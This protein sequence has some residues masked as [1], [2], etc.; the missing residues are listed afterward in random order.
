MGNCGGLCNNLKVFGGKGDIIL[1]K[2]SNNDTGKYLETDNAQKI[3]LLQ[4]ALKQ[5]LKKR[6]L[7]KQPYQKKR[8]QNPPNIKN[9]HLK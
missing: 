7:P 6:N 4:K 3:I 1:E 8:V 2:N 9:H 5:Y